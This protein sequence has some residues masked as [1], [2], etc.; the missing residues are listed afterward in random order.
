MIRRRRAVVRD[1]E[2]GTGF[3]PKIIRQA[4]MN[5]RWVVILLRIRGGRQERINVG[6]IGAVLDTRPVMILHE[7][8]ENGAAR[9]EPGHRDFGRGAEQSQKDGCDKEMSFHDRVVNRQEEGDLDYFNTSRPASVSRLRGYER[10]P[11]LCPERPRVGP[12]FRHRY[13]EKRLRR[14]RLAAQAVS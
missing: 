5:A 13:R 4:R 8:Y 3:E 12:R 2:T 7:Y 9:V 1:S 10:R 6:R 11:V 14:T